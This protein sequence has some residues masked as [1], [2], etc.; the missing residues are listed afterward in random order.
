M[1]A[2][3]IRTARRTPLP[4]PAAADSAAGKRDPGPLVDRDER[5]KIRKTATR[6]IWVG[7]AFQ[8]FAGTLQ[9]SGNLETER[10]IFIGLGITIGF[11]AVV[12]MMVLSQLTFS[13]VRPAWTRGA[14]WLSVL[15]GL[16][17]GLAIVGL[18]AYLVD[19]PVE[20]ITVLVS[21]GTGVRILLALIVF[22]VCAPLVEEIL[23][24]G[25]V[26]ESLRARGPL[27]AASASSA[28]FAAWHLRPPFW[29]FFVMG[30]ALWGLYWLR[31]LA[32]SMTCHAV[33]NGTL[34]VLAVMVV[35]GPSH[36]V[37]SGGIAVRAPQTWQRID[38]PGV[39]EIDLALSGPSGARLDI[40]DEEAPPGEPSADALGQLLRDGQIQFPALDLSEASVHVVEYKA[41][42]AVRANADFLGHAVQMAIVPRQS[43]VWFLALAT[44]GSARARA[45]FEDI[46]K[47]LAL[48]RT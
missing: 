40:F 48:P 39:P 2:A 22:A 41:G 16:A 12:S 32:A 4:V 11:Y 35:F 42:A 31:G 3:G 26:S 37:R 7:I 8:V 20:G 9:V 30:L 19:D 43:R 14:P 24:R 34:V 47:D 33:F 13:E 46:L 25:L 28:L 5:R 44:G 23:F 17:A 6:A 27:I 38:D 10:A 18:I 1:V 21:E 36:L 45:D 29:Y 15:A